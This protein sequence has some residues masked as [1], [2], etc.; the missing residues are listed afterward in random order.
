MR[1]VY[2]TLIALLTVEVAAQ[3]LETAVVT[4]KPAFGETVPDVKDLLLRQGDYEWS[5][6]W[7]SDKYGLKAPV[8][9]D[10]AKAYTFSVVSSRL[11]GPAV[12]RIEHEGKVIYDRSICDVH[13]LKM[14]TEKVPFIFGLAPSEDPAE[15]RGGEP[16]IRTVNQLFP[17]YRDFAYAGCVVEAGVRA[18]VYVCPQCREAYRDWK[19][20]QDGR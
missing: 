11:Q 1:I 2:Y 6:S 5:F 15:T 8:N 3:E 17:N 12:E 7:E 10:P 20:E 9:L 14:N 4:G 16:S 13:R 19:K 18:T